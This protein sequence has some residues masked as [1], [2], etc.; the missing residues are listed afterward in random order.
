MEPPALPDPPYSCGRETAGKGI[1]HAVLANDINHLFSHRAAK[2]CF[3]CSSL[4]TALLFSPVAFCRLAALGRAALVGRP[5][6]MA[7]QPIV[8]T[9]RGMLPYAQYRFEQA[10]VSS[11]SRLKLERFGNIRVP[12]KT[13]MRVS[14]HTCCVQSLEEI[15]KRELLVNGVFYRGGKER[16]KCGCVFL[17]NSPAMTLKGSNNTEERSGASFSVLLPFDGS[18]SLR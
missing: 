12:K 6:R 14:Y 1:A 2:K 9:H 5:G 3:P 18:R 11:C 8:S 15:A 13:R 16:V 4:Q 7:P 17:L 10:L